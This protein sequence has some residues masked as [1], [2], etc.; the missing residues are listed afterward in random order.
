VKG[1]RYRVELSV[2]A[3]GNLIQELED[4]KRNLDDRIK[5]FVERLAEVGIPVIETKI[6]QAQGDSNK[7][8]DTDIS[9]VSSGETTTA[10]LILSGT[11]ILFIEFPTGIYYNNTVH[12]PKA[13]EFGYGI[14]TYGRGQGLNPG[15]WW[16]KGEDEK[17]HFSRGT[18]CTM[19]MYSA[20][21][22]IIRQIETVAKEVFGNG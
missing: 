20:S 9:V 10:T 14:G 7:D 13:A 1:H 12:H 19:P 17:Y 21:L 2:D 3:I 18:E 6:M 8:H 4:Y 11:D 22:E 16:Y 15:Y 5:L